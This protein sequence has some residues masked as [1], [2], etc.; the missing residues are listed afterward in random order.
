MQKELINPNYLKLIFDFN[1]NL[2][3][4]F[5]GIFRYKNGSWLTPNLIDIINGSSIQAPIDI[6]LKKRESHEKFK[7]FIKE[8]FEHNL[9]RYIYE[10]QENLKDST[11]H[12]WES[13]HLYENPKDYLSNE[14]SKY[15][16]KE[17]ILDYFFRNQ[18][19]GCNQSLRQ[20]LLSNYLVNKG[21]S[22]LIKQFSKTALKNR[23]DSRLHNVFLETWKSLKNEHFQ[24]LQIEEIYNILIW[25]PPQNNKYA[26]KTITIIN[27]LAKKDLAFIKSN[28]Q[29][30][31]KIFEKFQYDLKVQTKLK[32]LFGTNEDYLYTSNKKSIFTEI[33]IEQNH[34]PFF[35]KAESMGLK[36]EKFGQI[37]FYFYSLFIKDIN[38][39]KIPSIKN[40]SSQTEKN[41]T[42]EYSI[43][44]EYGTNLDEI[45]QYVDSK[46]KQINK[47]QKAI[48]SS[49]NIIHDLNKLNEIDI[50]TYL[51]ETVNKI[52][53][54]EKMTKELKPNLN[55]TLKQNKI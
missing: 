1:V 40:Y 35:L 8:K 7:E 14:F 49:S 28:E 47:L 16:L 48:L 52:D 24:E 30:I 5:H 41:L 27:D 3:F 46:I 55:S 25:H 45:N 42:H 38:N 18:N 26:Q 23:N 54:F 36:K 19:Y 53:L 13:I 33:Q 43:I 12:I 44:T 21:D 50:F 32:D 9:L 37:G 31:L 29:K 6:D 20:D 10:R 51:N 22:N 15:I 17:N 39:N 11:K 34:K 2:S 4:D